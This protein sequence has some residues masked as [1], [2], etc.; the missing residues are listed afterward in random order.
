MSSRRRGHVDYRRRSD[1]SR[2]S[3]PIIGWVRFTISK[4]LRWYRLPYTLT[5]SLFYSIW[6]SSGTSW[7]RNTVTQ[8][9][10]ATR[11]TFCELNG[12]NRISYTLLSIFNKLLGNLFNIIFD[13]FMILFLMKST[14]KNLPLSQR[15]KS[16]SASILKDV[17]VRW[18]RQ[19]L[20]ME[21]I[22]RFE[23]VSS[24]TTRSSLAFL[25]PRARNFSFL[26]YYSSENTRLCLLS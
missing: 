5:S 4:L 19:G 21:Y 17:S 13:L 24:T 7:S 26:V 14:T 10:T 6:E 15:R 3:A 23:S 22:T 11:I 25:P 1:L 2:V 16:R 12:C 8:Q 9:S 20:V 18:V